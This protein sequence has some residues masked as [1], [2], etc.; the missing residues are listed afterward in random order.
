MTT[1]LTAQLTIKLEFTAI[2]QTPEL[3]SRSSVN[4]DILTPDRPSSL[5]ICSHK[6]PQNALSKASSCHWYIHR[7]RGAIQPSDASCP[8][9]SLYVV[10]TYR[11][12]QD[13]TPS[14]PSMTE[15]DICWPM[16]TWYMSWHVAICLSVVSLPSKLFKL[17]CGPF[18]RS[19]ADQTSDL[20][21]GHQRG[22]TRP[23]SI[24]RLETIDH[25]VTVV[26]GG[27]PPRLRNARILQRRGSRDVGTRDQSIHRR[28][29]SLW[30]GG[31]HIRKYFSDFG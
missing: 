23:H 8:Q 2:V 25:P 27:Y 31:L 22:R 4:T 13:H 17:E 5:E 20:R 21:F 10:V 26:P 15:W 12:T 18:F 3:W 24:S 6:C 30:A 7:L 16:A 28:R 1:S 9:T 11:D 14:D 19:W 29:C